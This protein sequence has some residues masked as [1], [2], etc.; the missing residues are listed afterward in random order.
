MN[1]SVKEMKELIAL[2]TTND[3]EGGNEMT[4][5]ARVELRGVDADGDKYY[6]EQKGKTIKE[7]REQT[8]AASQE[9]N[10]EE[11]EMNN[12]TRVELK[13]VDADGDEYYFKGRG[14]TIKELR[15]ENKEE[16]KE[17]TYKEFVQL[18]KDNMI[19][20]LSSFQDIELDNRPVPLLV[21]EEKH[22]MEF[23]ETYEPEVSEEWELQQM[24]SRAEAEAKAGTGYKKEEELKMKMDLQFFGK[25]KEEEMKKEKE[26]ENLLS[27]YFREKAKLANEK[28]GKEMEYKHDVNHEDW[29]LDNFEYIDETIYIN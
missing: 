16:K 13:G 27:D 21:E 17:M 8:E 5:N 15:A 22:S 19:E 20:V 29:M 11:I 4:N 12:N 6:F 2:L 23:K 26:I 24:R 7:L 28:E 3:Q 25:N 14:K 1:K 18:D 10:K 9:N